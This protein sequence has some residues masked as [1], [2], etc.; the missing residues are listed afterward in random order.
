M[1]ATP[2]PVVPLEVEELLTWLRVERGRA[3]NTVGAY[4][5]DLTAYVAWLDGQ[6]GR[7]RGYL[8]ARFRRRAAEPTTDYREC[9]LGLR[10]PGSDQCPHDDRDHDQ[11]Q[12]QQSQQRSTRA[13]MRCQRCQSE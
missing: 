5:R 9:G 10:H 2:T 3:A 11:A 8:R 4:R 12:G 13:E 1:T 7:C 6:G